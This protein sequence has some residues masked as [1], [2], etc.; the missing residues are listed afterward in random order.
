MMKMLKRLCIIAML[1]CIRIFV[2]EAQDYPTTVLDGPALTVDSL[3][4]KPSIRPSIMLMPVY[5]RFPLVQNPSSLAMP[6]FETKEQRA[7]RVNFRAFSAVMTSVDK[8]LYWH[9]PPKLQK[10][11][12]Q[13]LGAA[14]LFLSNP[15]AF[16]EGCVPLM[17][18]SFPFIYA[19][20]PG[21]A[22][23]E[24]PYTSSMFPKCID[25][26]FD[27]ATGT[28]KQVSVDWSEIQKRMSASGI[29]QSTQ[30]VPSVNVTPVERMM[31]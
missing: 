11:W 31:H 19:K 12:K 26:E 15:N 14:R 20:T 21:M 9:R 16:P 24:N 3:S 30:P 17:N 4:T 18:T 6:L 2:M 1:L 29:G 8:D 28:Y 10:P 13:I 22:P 27:I 5:P 7:A 23:Y 25:T